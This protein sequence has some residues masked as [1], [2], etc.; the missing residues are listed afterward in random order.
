[1]RPLRRC[2]ALAA[3]LGLSLGGAAG[4]A[5][6]P[7]GGPQILHIPT[8]ERRAEQ[9]ILRPVPI[10]VELP[11]EVSTRARR[12]LLHY[13]LWGEPDWTTL[14]LR[15]TMTRYEGAIPCL[16]VSTVTGD[17]RYY[18]RVHDA[19]GHVIAS[20]ASIARPYIVT[21]KHDAQ[22]AAGAPRVARCPDPADC[23]HGLPGCPSDR[24]LEVPCAADRD[25]AP[26]MSCSF[27]GVC[28][29]TE[30]RNNWIVLSVEQGVGVVGTSGACSIP[31]Q[32]DGAFACYRADGAQY[33]GS[34]V[35]TNEP[36]GAGPTPTRI[37]AGYERL[38]HYD[39]TVGVR[40]G[41]AVRGSGPTPPGGTP[42]MPISASARVTH[43]FGEDPFMRTGL[44]PF[45]FVTAGYEMVDVPVRIHVREDPTK[46]HYQGGN[47]LEQTL[48]AWKRA[49][50]GFAGAGAGLAY[51][52]IRRTAIFVEVAA[53]ETFPFSAFVVAPSAGVMVGF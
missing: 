23:P 18:I 9:G 14:E 33:L 15:R 19:D 6:P 51:A 10:A 20:A 53:F 1:V 28:E 38:V 21:I 26:G 49:G 25:C 35:L 52:M 46:V 11:N 36:A 34:P 37:V 3:A 50:D 22:L 5:E 44:R 27:R 47:D 29:R 12:V 16:E 39:T 45:A 48:D 2:A 40:V 41:A 30:R 8:L 24:V 17:L 31:S 4:S 42:F 32:E 13:R 7:D 43:W